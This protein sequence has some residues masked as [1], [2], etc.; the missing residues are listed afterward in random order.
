MASQI[1]SRVSTFLFRI[2]RCG[3]VVLLLALNS[4]AAEPVAAPKT[5]PTVA[6]PKE[7]SQKFFKMHESFLQRGKEGPIG[8]LFLGDSITEGWGKAPEVWNQFY[9]KY[10]PAN[11]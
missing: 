6:A 3:L 5:D 7:G 4:I 11:F 2:I 8:V 9:G 1:L 10:Q